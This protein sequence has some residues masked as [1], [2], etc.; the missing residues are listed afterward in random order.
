VTKTVIGLYDDLADAQRAVHELLGNG[1]APDDIS[2]LANKASGEILPDITSESSEYAAALETERA[3]I[4]S[5][6]ELNTLT[7]PGIGVTLTVGSLFSQR[8]D[9]RDST[10]TD[11]L[12]VLLS[13]GVP[14]ERT[15]CY[16]EGIRR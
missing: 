15:H 10:R 6:A 5:T 13:F 4:G 11:L 7:I 12:D 2:I 3:I 14:W 16:A 9:D 1:F 8:A